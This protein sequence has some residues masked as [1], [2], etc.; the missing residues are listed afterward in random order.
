MPKYHVKVQAEVI[1]ETEFD[2]EAETIDDALIYGDSL[3]ELPQGQAVIC[4]LERVLRVDVETVE[5]KT[6]PPSGY[7]K[8]SGARSGRSKRPA[9]TPRSGRS[10][11]RRQSRA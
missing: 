3:T 5:D 7:A 8:G 10:R 11:R 4:G 2:Y 9:A 1:V 6:P